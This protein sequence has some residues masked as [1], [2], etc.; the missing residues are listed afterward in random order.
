MDTYKLERIEERTAILESPRGKMISVPASS[1]PA[2]AKE[3][4]CLE[5][6]DGSFVILKEETSVRR[7]EIS[8]LL[9]GLVQKN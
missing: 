1:V 7:K 6:K 4:D 2:E 9:L 5:L 8:D 3:G